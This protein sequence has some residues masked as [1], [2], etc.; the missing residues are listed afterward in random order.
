MRQ[1]A[2][3]TCAVQQTRPL[4]LGA[5]PQARPRRWV[6]QLEIAKVRAGSLEGIR[7]LSDSQIG[8]RCGRRRSSVN[9][10]NS[11]FKGGKPGKE[12]LKG[13]SNNTVTATKK[14]RNSVA[15]AGEVMEASSGG[16]WSSHASPDR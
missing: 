1:N 11:S 15:V 12:G 4:A 7:R 8:G 9:G 10:R 3:T 16:S 6:D 2:D 13:D 14:I 5:L